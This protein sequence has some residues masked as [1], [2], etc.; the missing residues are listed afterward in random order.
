MPL[1]TQQSR[2][3]LEADRELLKLK[4]L[5][6]LD[7][8]LEQRNGPI[9]VNVSQN[10]LLAWRE[11][12]S[13]LTDLSFLDLFR[14]SSANLPFQVKP[15]VS[16]LE[17][18]FR[19]LSSLVSEQ[20]KGVRGNKRLQLLK[21]IRV[22][23]IYPEEI[24]NASSLQRQIKDLQEENEQLRKRASE[25]DERCNELLEELLLAR[26]EQENENKRAQSLEI[27]LEDSLQENIKLK[28]YIDFIED[29]LIDE[30]L[31]NNGK[32]LSEVGPRQK[33]RKIKELTTNV[34][35]A[36]WF[37]ESFGLKLDVLLLLDREGTVQIQLDKNQQG[38]K[39]VFNSLCEDDKDKIR[40]VLFI[41]DRFCISDAAYH[42]LTM[43]VA[44]LERSYLVRQCR[45]NINNLLHITRTPGYEPGVQMSFKE[46]LTYQLEQVSTTLVAFGV[47]MGVYNS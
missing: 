39:S 15:G 45:N 25:L 28:E 46:E 24:I 41:M 10:V 38:Q 26:K 29:K 12:K 17:E 36:L 27:E 37:V 5:P 20:L 2:S 47:V 9:K 14:L 7:Y 6:S 31:R 23:F 8:I 13:K 42:E 33:I 4:S 3:S 16:R 1:N 19:V 35:K 21:K 30:D 34:E 40:A 22:V 43:R 32:K 44:G 18:R 11:I